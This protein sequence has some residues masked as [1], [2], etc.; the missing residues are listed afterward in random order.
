MKNNGKKRIHIKRE[1]IKLLS[2]GK[3]FSDLFKCSCCK[4]CHS[5]GFIFKGENVQTYL[6][7]YECKNRLTSKK[8]E[9]IPQNKIIYS[10]FESNRSKH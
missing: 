8:N 6:I 9:T 1:N 5:S 2:K 7:C 10:N 3:P 4:I